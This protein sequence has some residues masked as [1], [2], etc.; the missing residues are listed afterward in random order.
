MKIYIKNH[1]FHYEIENVTRLFFPF[2]K[3]EVIKNIEKDIID[4]DNLKVPYIFTGVEDSVILVKA[5]FDD[6]KKELTTDKSNS[7][8]E[9][10]R[11]ICSLLFK[12]LTEYT[13]IEMPWGMITGVRPVK[14]FRTLAFEKGKEYAKNYFKNSYF[15]TDDK[16]KLAE[17]TEKHE[18]DILN[19]SK[20]NSFSLYISIPFCPSRCSYCSFV[21]QS[22][23]RTRHLIEPYLDC[24]CKEI[25]FTGQIVKK[26]NLFLE[27]V[28]IGGGTPTTL[29]PNQ[30]KKLVN[31]VNFSFDMTTC[32]EFTVEAGRPDTITEEKL[33]TLKDN[34]VT[35]ISINPQTL[36]DD[37]LKE[38][39]RKHSAEE[40][41]KAFE[42]AKKVNF[43]TV[44][45]DL[46]AGLPTDTFESFKNSLDTIIHYATENITIHTLS[47]KR[48]ASLTEQGIKTNAQDAERTGKMLKYAEERLMQMN[49]IPYYLY[50][51]SRMVGNYE[52][53]GWS[54]IGNE[55][56]YNVFIM[57]ETHT[58]LACGAGG[59]T[60]LKN[61]RTGTL[62]RIFNYKFPYE[63][64]DGFS[65]ILKRKEK[66]DIFF[67]EL[68]L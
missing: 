17:T 10:E 66:V 4:F 25:E 26:Y 46:I 12:L 29:N 15:V 41:I 5:V 7:I 47:I 21:S 59:A 40:T 42:I 27:T 23:E 9:D 24:L 19:S 55:G 34:G 63:Y 36:N 43:T 53:V 56:L 31:T 49:Y 60:K 52:N 2:E 65:E 39:G 13:G 68:E 57:D 32:R 45:S 30:L 37:V 51:Q 48:S 3:L 38:I 33:R 20:E 64:I 1:V 6:F 35:R 61:P 50:R 44:N 16:I 54:K 22:I 18:N 28:Y 58:I 11:L 62:E 8:K 14:Y 67:K